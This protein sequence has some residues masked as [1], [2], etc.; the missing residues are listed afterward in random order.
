MSEVP[1]T[2]LC[3]R[4]CELWYD[5]TSLARQRLLHLRV[6]E[7]LADMARGHRDPDRQIAGASA[8]QIAGH[9]RLGGRA[10]TAAQYYEVA[11]DRARSLYANADAMADY[12]AALAL[13]LLTWRR[14][15]RP[16]AICRPCPGNTMRHWQATERPPHWV[17][18]VPSRGSSTRWAMSINAG[19][20]GTGRN[21][22]MN[23]PWMPTARKD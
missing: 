15:T 6:A 4:N 14:C 1:S 12:R 17:S 9:Y 3:T 11:G 19:G 2:T 18:R 7:T 5:E 21:A 20:N 10:S 22:T 13:G 16:L 23:L 8:S